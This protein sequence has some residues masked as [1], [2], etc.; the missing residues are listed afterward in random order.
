MQERC[1]CLAFLLLLVAA[2]DGVSHVLGLS[3]GTNKDLTMLWTDDARSQIFVQ[4]AVIMKSSP[5]SHSSPSWQQSHPFV[6][7]FK[8]VSFGK[9]REMKTRLWGKAKFSII[10]QDFQCRS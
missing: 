4:M 9:P 7:W 1:G 3:F 6:V 8:L 2:S 5:S 10:F